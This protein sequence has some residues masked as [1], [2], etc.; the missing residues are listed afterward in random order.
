[1]IRIFQLIKKECANTNGLSTANEL[2]TLK[3]ITENRIIEYIRNIQESDLLD[4]LLKD[5]VPAHN[6]NNLLRTQIRYM[7]PDI[8]EVRIDDFE[9]HDS[10]SNVQLKSEDNCMTAD[11]VDL[12]NESVS[13]SNASTVI[14]IL[15]PEKFKTEKMDEIHDANIAEG[16]KVKEG[17][18]LV[19]IHPVN[20]ICKAAN[21]KN[22]TDID[23]DTTNNEDTYNSTVQIPCNE[24]AANSAAEYIAGVNSETLLIKTRVIQAL[25]KTEA[26]NN[27]VI[28]RINLNPTVHLKRLRSPRS[29][30]CKI[31][32][33]N[34]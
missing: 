23:L 31:S 16:S 21:N 24:L 22:H 25:S 17:K 5:T 30:S 7:T 33:L 13:A 26:K 32:K 14:V 27:A 12:R 3:E 10:E 6:E 29:D 20:Q 34:H 1:M 9:F 19:T 28:S 15:S 18:V 2:T 11:A 8:G 4:Q